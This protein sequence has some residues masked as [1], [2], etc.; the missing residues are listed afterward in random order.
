MSG[1][2]TVVGVDCAVDPRNVGLACAEYREGRMRLAEAGIGVSN[3]DLVERIVGAA[4][5]G[6]RV[7]LALDAPLGWP[8]PLG[9]TLAAHRA[10]QSIE[11]PANQLFRRETDLRVREQ[12]RKAPLEVGADRIARTAVAALD[13]LAAVGRARNA[14]IPLAWSP[15]LVADW[16]A[17]EVYPAGTLRA[18]GLVA[19]GYKRPDQ[20]AVRADLARELATRIE[21][22]DPGAIARGA[23]HVLDAVVCVLAAQDF[24]AGHADPPRDVERSRREGWIWVRTPAARPAATRS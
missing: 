21:I 12:L 2:V 10:G 13:L 4:R 8:S 16:S 18:H 9:E 17:I 5:H 22:S 7:L 11:R 3:A 15:E 23:S 19:S 1:S 20:V 14:P 24:L 6:E